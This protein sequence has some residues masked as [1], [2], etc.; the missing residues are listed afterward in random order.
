MST[1]MQKQEGGRTAVMEIMVNTGRISE[2]IA[3]EEET[4]IL[5]KSFPKA[6]MTEW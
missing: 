4:K 2:A 3:D 1:S 5:Q 6:N